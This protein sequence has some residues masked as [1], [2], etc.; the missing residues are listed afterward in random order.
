[1]LGNL[2]SQARLQLHLRWVWNKVI[3][4]NNSHNVAKAYMY[5]VRPIRCAKIIA[6]QTHADSKGPFTLRVHTRI[7]IFARIHVLYCRTLA[8]IDPG[9][10]GQKSR[11]HVMKYAAGV[12]I[13]V[14]RLLRFL[15]AVNECRIV[16]CWRR[17]SVV[18]PVTVSFSVEMYTRRLNH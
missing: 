1:M 8:C 10:N 3:A 2:A 9:S 12:G 5:S 14:K 18:W 4:V 6:E 16:E 11:S 17:A 7:R 13:H 15:V